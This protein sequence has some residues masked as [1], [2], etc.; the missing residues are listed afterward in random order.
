MINEK[1]FATVLNWLRLQRGMIERANG[2]VMIMVCEQTVHPHYVHHGK[3]HRYSEAV[4]RKTGPATDRWGTCPIAGHLSTHFFIQANGRTAPAPC[5]MH[6]MPQG[7]NV[8]DEVG[9]AMEAAQR[10]GG[11]LALVEMLKKHIRF[12]PFYWRLWD[13]T[14][15]YQRGVRDGEYAG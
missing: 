10:T 15:W 6:P 12:D 3:L 8:K 4:E 1:Q 5:R 7:L 2:D 13:M 11:T 14:V 9:A